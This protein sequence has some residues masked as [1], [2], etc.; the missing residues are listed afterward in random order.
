MTE[1]EK[2]EQETVTVE[3]SLAAAEAREREAAVA[4]ARLRSELVQ[5]RARI[6]QLP[7]AAEGP[8]ELH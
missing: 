3:Q 6:A 2:L 4:T 1:R 5:L 8:F 7:A